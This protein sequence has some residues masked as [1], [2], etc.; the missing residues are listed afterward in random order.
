MSI[1]SH[2]TFVA[3]LPRS[4]SAWVANLLTHGDCFAYHEP[5]RWD[6]KREPGAPPDFL[7]LAGDI[8]LAKD[9]PYRGSPYRV[10]FC[11]TAFGAY[12][13]QA[14][15]MCPDARVLI[16]WRPLLEVL[17]GWNDAVDGWGMEDLHDEDGRVMIRL[18]AGLREL[19]HWCDR[20]GLRALNLTSRILGDP[21]YVRKVW[22]FCTAGM[23]FD[24][25][26]ARMLMDLNVEAILPRYIEAI[27]GKPARVRQVNFANP[28]SL[29]PIQDGERNSL[30]PALSPEGGEGGGA[31]GS[32]NPDG[33]TNYRAEGWAT[34]CGARQSAA[35]ELEGTCR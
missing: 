19:A 4:R 10:C 12:W 33:R 7:R 26:R 15:E 21:D 34:E 25:R 22:N 31:T 20:N 1:S 13:R 18:E 11:D 24:E 32:S 16:L 9:S 14:L 30:T 2:I 8:G 27:E 28:S 17:K 23:P 29:S 35:T 3:S 5:L 6:S